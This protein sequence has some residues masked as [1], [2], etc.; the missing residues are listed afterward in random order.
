MR[1]GLWREGWACRF[2][3]LR[4][5]RLDL[6]CGPNPKEGYL[7]VD[8]RDYGRSDILVCDLRVPWKWDDESVD[9]VYC[10]QF[11]EHLTAH[12]RIHFA[13][14]LYRVLKPGAQAEIIVPHWSSGRAYG[15]LTHQWPPVSEFWFL[16]LSRAWRES[17]APHTV[18]DYTCDFIVESGPRLH[19]HIALRNQEHQQFAAAFYKEAVQD[20]VS[21]WT[22][23][24]A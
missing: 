19:P 9:A 17:E 15:D 4:V 22:K 1:C 21:T 14:E 5:V 24:E 3:G 16:Y 10:N 20:L 13:N 18:D 2:G 6:G 23:P 7:G 12:E 8:I 11:V